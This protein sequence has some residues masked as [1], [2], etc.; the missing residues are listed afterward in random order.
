MMRP[1]ATPVPGSGVGQVCATT[2]TTPPD[3]ANRVPALLTLMRVG[4]MCDERIV[5]YELRR[6]KAQ[7]ML[8]RVDA[9]LVF[10]PCPAQRSGLT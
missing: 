1:T 4:P 3:P 5:E 6:L 10:V 9:V 7:A 2:T 8:L